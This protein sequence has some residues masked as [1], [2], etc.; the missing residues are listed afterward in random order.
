M[1]LVGYQSV[2]K[3]SILNWLIN[4]KFC[5]SYEATVG[6][7]YQTYLIEVEGNSYSLQIWDTA[8]Q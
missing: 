5:S 6:I 7:D 3:S 2:G 1:I 8:G 4:R